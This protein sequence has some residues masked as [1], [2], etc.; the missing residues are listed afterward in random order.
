MLTDVVL[1][2][3]GA[4]WNKNSSKEQELFACFADVQ[5]IS[6]TPRFL[7]V[8]GRIIGGVSLVVR[9]VLP[10]GEKWDALRRLGTLPYLDRTRCL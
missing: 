1:L 4:D 10:L 6:K 8:F 2:A 5:N 7:E 3:A 9:L